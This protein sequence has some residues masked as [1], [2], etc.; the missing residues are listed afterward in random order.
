MAWVPVGTQA[1]FFGLV[2]TLLA[3]AGACWVFKVMVRCL[4][5]HIE[6]GYLTHE[7]VELKHK[8][9][10]L[11]LNGLEPLFGLVIHG[12]LFLYNSLY[13]GSSLYCSQFLTPMPMGPG[14]VVP[15][16]LLHGLLEVDAVEPTHVRYTDDRIR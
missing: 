8:V 16:L 14:S 6:P 3:A 13:L 4:H 7:L 2:Q 12:S 9:P 1:F 5:L 11:T 15:H 10:N